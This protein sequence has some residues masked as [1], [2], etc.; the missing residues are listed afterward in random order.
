MAN[1]GDYVTAELVGQD[2]TVQGVFIKTD[3]N[4]KAL[5]KG[6]VS[7]YVCEPSLVKVP[8]ENL[9]IFPDVL[10]FVKQTRSSLRCNN[11]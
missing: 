11:A 1:I 2:V 6:Q 4:G 8:D 5:V 7:S 3:E 9:Y 10:N